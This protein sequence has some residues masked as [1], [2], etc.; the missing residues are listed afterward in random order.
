MIKEQFKDSYKLLKKHLKDIDESEATFQPDI[1]NNNIKWQLG[2][3]ILLNDFLVFETINGD[4]AL[5]Q[6]VTKYFL[7]GTS[8]LN[9]DGNEPS[10]EELKLLLDEQFDRIFNNLEEQ[11]KKDRSEAIVLKDSGI[12]MESFNESI[13]FAIIHMNRHFGQIVMLKSMIH[14]LK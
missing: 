3:L 8:P 9:F 6:P 10:F 14:K 2:H 1:A 12:V 13:H 7:W 11:L 4:N 5:K